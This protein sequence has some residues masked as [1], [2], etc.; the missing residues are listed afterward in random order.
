M[1]TKTCAEPKC[2]PE[3]SAPTYDVL[4]ND[5][6]AAYVHVN[7]ASYTGAYHYLTQHPELYDPAFRSGDEAVFRVLPSQ[8]R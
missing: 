2:T 8:A 3:N 6:H 5:F 7:R 4:V 1:V